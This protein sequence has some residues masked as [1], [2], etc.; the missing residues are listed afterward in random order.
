MAVRCCTACTRPV[1]SNVKEFGCFCDL[2]G[3]PNGRCEGLVHISQMTADG[4]V[5]RVADVAKR[6]QRVWVKVI[7]MVG[8]KVGLSMREVDQ[9]TGAD[10]KPRADPTSGRHAA[11]AAVLT[12]AAGNED[13]FSNPRAPTTASSASSSIRPLVSASAASQG[14]TDSNDALSSRRPRARLTSPERWEL[15]QLIA[16][17]ALKASDRPS[18]FSDDRV[19]VISTA[20]D[21]DDDEEVDIELNDVEPAFLRGQTASAADLSPI[22]VVKNPE[23]SMQ[24]AALTQ[25]ALS[26]ERRELREQQ[27]ADAMDVIPADLSRSWEDP[28]ANP[29]ERHLAAEIRNIGRGQVEEAPTWRKET[30]GKNVTYGRATTLTIIEQRQSL[31]IFKL[32]EQLLQAVNSNQLLVVIGETGSGKCFARGTR[33][34]LFDGDTVA[35]ESVAGGE[36][37]MG[38]DGLPRTV[39]P[40]SLTQ[41]RDT[42]YRITPK[43]DGAEPFTVNGAHILVLVN[44]VRPSKAQQTQPAAVGGRC[45]GGSW[46]PTACARGSSVVACPQR[47]WRRPRS[48]S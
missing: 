45:A 29:A 1:V 40:G 18:A 21:D 34:R 26:K 17:G 13:L 37:L 8:R 7:S 28:M 10:L 6:G 33:L 42:L 12:V 48:T 16:S 4:R 24:R 39:T 22:K 35:V 27:K 11:A 32:R 31:P 47:R 44:N 14:R 25:S 19:G 43:W 2:Q 46:T 3:C 5:N 23:G 41:G 20:A 36:R 38:D 30:M 9:S 15:D